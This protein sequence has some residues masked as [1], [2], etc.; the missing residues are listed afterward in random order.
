MSEAGLARERPSG[1][2]RTSPQS[3]HVVRTARMP[4]RPT[5]T[6]AETPGTE[7]LLHL[8]QRRARA[9]GGMRTRRPDDILLA[10]DISLRARRG[11]DE[12]WRAADAASLP[13]RSSASR[14]SLGL[15]GPSRGGPYK[16]AASGIRTRVAGLETP[17]TN[18]A[19]RWLRAPRAH[20]R[21]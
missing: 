9:G 10:R 2:R 19:I 5:R 3:R 8:R 21:H 18:Q 13:M 11:S 15:N 20:P 6:R 14:R 1:T 7:R 4:E 12:A 16:Y 17:Y